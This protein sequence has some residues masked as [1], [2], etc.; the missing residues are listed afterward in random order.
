MTD[1]VRING[2]PFSW[3]SSIFKVDGFPYKGILEFNYEQKRERKVV[4][5]ARRDGVPLGK[6]PG[7]YSVPSMSLKMLKGSADILTTYLTAKGL[8]SYGDASFVFIMQCIEPDPLA[9]P[10]NV[11]CESCTIDGKKDSAAE[12][13]DELVTEFEIGCLQLTENAK[14]LWSVVRGLP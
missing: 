4:Y 6:T 14:R 12:G 8:G 2:V 3:A 5:G 7:K 11:V 13:I 10:L 1:L 9:T